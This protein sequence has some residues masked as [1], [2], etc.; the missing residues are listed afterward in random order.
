M[1]PTLSFQPHW[2]YLIMEGGKTI[3][4]RTWTT[5]YRGSFHVHASYG[6]KSDYEACQRFLESRGIEIELPPL[7][8]LMRGEIIGTVFLSKIT[9]PAP[10]WG[11]PSLYESLYRW[12]M[13]QIKYWWHLEKPQKIDP[14]QC[15]GQLGWFFPV[16]LL[17][18]E[19]QQ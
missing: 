15:R 2:A 4:N 7:A 14:I 19:G 3:E 12:G 6:K 13:P 16:Q 1:I 18:V 17:G 9:S 5:G 8:D 11:D 10:M